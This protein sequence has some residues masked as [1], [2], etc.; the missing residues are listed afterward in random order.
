[1]CV[2]WKKNNLYFKTT[3]QKFEKIKKRLNIFIKVMNYI[4]LHEEEKPITIYYILSD[5]KK[6]IEKNTFISPKHINSG[7]ADTLSNEIFIWRDEEF[8]KVS[9]HELI[10][11]FNNIYHYK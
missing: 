11:L 1:V 4:Q 6:K 3:F 7:Y 2:S 10:H 9:F 8:E 5:L